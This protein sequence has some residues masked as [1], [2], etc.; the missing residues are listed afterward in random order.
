MGGLLTGTLY[1]LEV[2]VVLLGFNSQFHHFS[3]KL[4]TKSNLNDMSISYFKF[5]NN[6]LAPWLKVRGDSIGEIFACVTVG[7][8]IGSHAPSSGMISI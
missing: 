7:L 6:F 5:L 4:G 2:T 8:F 3:I 1:S